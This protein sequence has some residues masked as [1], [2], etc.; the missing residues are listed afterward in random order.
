MGV[1]LTSLA[2]GHLF[3]ER[4]RC[5]HCRVLPAAEFA[6]WNFKFPM[7]LSVIYKGFRWKSACVNKMVSKTVIRP[8]HALGNILF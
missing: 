2:I 3:D 7:L 6:L 8:M 1:N 5:P 4:V